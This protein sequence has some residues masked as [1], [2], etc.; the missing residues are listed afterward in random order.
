[1]KQWTLLQTVLVVTGWTRIGLATVFFG[2]ISVT[3]GW[4]R[5]DVS[6]WC[7]RT[8]AGVLCGIAKLRVR[9]TGQ[10]NL[11]AAP[12]AVLISN[13]H[14]VLDIAVLGTSLHRDYRWLA[15]AELFRIPFLGWHLSLM[16]H[17][18][19]YR[20]GQRFKNADLGE[21]L[22]TVFDEGASA[23]FFPEGTRNLVL[24]PFQLGAFQTAVDCGQPVLPLVLTGTNHS[25]DVVLEDVRECTFEVLPP[26]TAPT[27]GTPRERAEALRDACHA[28]MTAALAN[29]AARQVTEVPQ[30]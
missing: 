19:V 15:K 11:D 16:G 27:E 13:H 18:P 6:R 28:A 1:V 25:T 22:Q 26:M 9:V 29:R 3:A 21:R 2:A 30:D 20:G 24:G 12:Q 14:T 5:P 17:V 4:F 23:L 7:M 8:W 10:E